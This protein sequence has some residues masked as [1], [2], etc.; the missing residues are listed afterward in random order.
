MSL[1]DKIYEEDNEVYSSTQ[2]N[3][4][5]SNKDPNE[6]SHEDFRMDSALNLNHL[7]AKKK[8]PSFL[9]TL[10]NHKAHTD[11]ERVSN[12]RKRLE[13]KYSGNRWRMTNEMFSGV[14]VKKK[15][16]PGAQRDK[17]DKTGSDSTASSKLK[18]A[19]P[20]NAGRKG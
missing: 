17:E 9:E 3:E 4:E 10:Y 13:E 1:G 19:S 11:Q 6:K 16:F 7:M 14:G 2:H 12:A 15:I 5:E 8:D 20:F 18:I